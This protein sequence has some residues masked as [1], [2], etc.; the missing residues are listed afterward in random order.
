ME[1]AIERR[2]PKQVRVPLDDLL[3]ELHHDG[4]GEA[5][6]ADGINL[7]R[8]GL[9]LRSAVL[10]DVGSRLRCSFRSP[11][12]GERISTD[13]EV[14]WSQGRRSEVGEFG[15]RFTDVA[16]DDQDIIEEVVHA[17]RA[18]LSD[19]APE[20]LQV[21]LD[22]VGQAI[23]AEV[24]HG[25][26]DAL[27]LEQALPFLRI[28]TGVETA[29]GRR[30]EL[31]AVDLRLEGET[32]RLVLTIWYSDGEKVSSKLPSDETLLDLSEEDGGTTAEGV[33]NAAGHSENL[34]GGRLGSTFDV[35][36][37]AMAALA[38]AETGPSAED[39][40]ASAERPSE[41]SLRSSGAEEGIG[42]HGDA[43]VV[44]AGLADAKRGDAK[45]GDAQGP[46]GEELASSAM[47]KATKR[48]KRAKKAP[49]NASAL[50]SPVA[51]R[52]Q[53]GLAS[54]RTKLAPLGGK[55]RHGIVA[56]RV[57]MVPAFRRMLLK[58]KAGF[59]LLRDRL[60]E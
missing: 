60:P 51:V 54:L 9:S 4:L 49:L 50:G 6:E 31:Q 21:R 42:D 58:A 26:G 57:R 44:D 1:A 18:A 22:G 43:E 27:V 20:R 19:G 41:A 55:L 24:V 35:D 16:D 14:V 3:V 38:M 5:F 33:V 52:L 13:A 29:A 10:P 25:S 36:A 30:G 2:D 56:L 46:E 7:A 23:D 32:P 15:L 17:W 40:A 11:L 53:G 34:R 48:S 8:G 59:A 47:V 12:S 28:G 39:E 45:R 37:R